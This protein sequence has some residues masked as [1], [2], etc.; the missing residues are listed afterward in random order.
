MEDVPLKR[1]G[2]NNE[3]FR[4]R[5]S[6]VC[7]YHVNMFQCCYSIVK[8]ADRNYDIKCLRRIVLEAPVV[9]I[10]LYILIFR[11]NYEQIMSWDKKN[12]NFFIKTMAICVAFFKFYIAVIFIVLLCNYLLYCYQKFYLKNPE[13]ESIDFENYLLTNPEQYDYCRCLQDCSSD[14]SSSE[15]WS[16]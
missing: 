4:L 14:I 16:N 11:F 10:L 12:I 7:N 13:Y 3:C 15:E 5:H 9:F 6:Y 2:C 8:E 1:K